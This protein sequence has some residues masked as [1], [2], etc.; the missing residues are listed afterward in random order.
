MTFLFGILVIN[1]YLRFLPRK[2]I[3]ILSGE[4]FIPLFPLSSLPIRLKQ[5]FPPALLPLFFYLSFFLSFVHV[6]SLRQF[7]QLL[8]LL[9]IYLLLHFL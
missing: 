7:H 2:E 3:G 1:L 4:S 5:T 9:F 6:D 8:Y